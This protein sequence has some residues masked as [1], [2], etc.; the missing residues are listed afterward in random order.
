MYATIYL[1]KTLGTFFSA[2]LP[3]TFAV[4][5]AHGLMN[6]PPIFW[7]FVDLA[8]CY[9]FDRELAVKFSAVANTRL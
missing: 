1:L 3:G 6:S 9:V 7:R 5:L 4:I 8:N 2:S